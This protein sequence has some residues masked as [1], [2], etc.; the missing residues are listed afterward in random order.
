M[1]N[2]RISHLIERWITI[3]QRF[4][5]GV[6]VLIALIT[7]L[8]LWLI[9][10]HL[11]MTTDTRDMLSRDLKWRQL[12]IKY[13]DIFTETLDNVLIV[14]EADTPD[15][16]REDATKLYTSLKASPYFIEDIYFPSAISF[17]VK[18]HFFL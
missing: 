10:N 11:G 12:D 2:N 3:I 17:F 16:A 9:V 13:E 8:S 7:L 5:F 15:R 14:I 6:F 1:N 18:Q 4:R